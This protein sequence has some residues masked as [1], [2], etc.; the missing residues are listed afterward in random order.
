MGLKKIGGLGSYFW[1]SLIL[2]S[3]L[4]SLGGIVSC[5]SSTG[6][7]SSANSS[8]GAGWYIT[9]STSAPSVSASRLDVVQVLAIVKD[10]NNSPAVKGTNV[11]LTATRG[12]FL[13]TD[14]T[15]NTKILASMCAPT[16]NDIGQT[17]ATYIAAV[18]GTVTSGGSTTTTMIPIAPGTDTITASAMGAFGST[19]IQVNP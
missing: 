12:G 7:S 4:L 19:V 6:S 1:K 5:T 11:C 8:T 14:D 17:Q 13:T 2:I 3:A 9:V 18:T 10:R 15:G 16:T